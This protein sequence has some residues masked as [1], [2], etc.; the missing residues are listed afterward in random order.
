APE[1]DLR[2]VISSDELEGTEDGFL[3]AETV[4]SD[5]EALTNMYTNR[6]YAYADVGAKYKPSEAD[7]T[8]DVLFVL[9]KHQKVHIRRVFLEGN[10]MTRD[11]VIL[12]QVA[13]AD[14]DEYDGQAIERTIQRLESLDYF[15]GVDVE[16]IP[17]GDPSEMDLKVAVEEKPTGAIGGGVGYSS[18][19]G[20]YLGGSVSERNL[21]GKGYNLSL[22]GKFGDDEAG[23]ELDFYN[24]RVNDE[25]WGFGVNSALTE[26]DQGDYDKNSFDNSVRTVHAL[27]GKTLLTLEYGLDFYRIADIDEDASES[28]KDAEGEHAASTF[29]TD[30]ARS[31]V[32]KASFFKSDGTNNAASMTFGGGFLGGSD[33]FVKWAFLSEMYTPIVGDL[34]FHAKGRMGFLHEN[35]GGNDVPTSQR[36]YLGG[37]STIRGYSANKIASRDD[38]GDRIGGNKYLIGNAELFYPLSK[39]YGILGLLFFDAGNAWKEGE[40]FFEEVDPVGGENLAAA[41]SFGVYKSV[42]TGLRWMSPM[43]PLQIEYGYGLDDLD[44][45]GQHKIEFMMGQQF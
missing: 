42:G 1:A 8:V 40:W 34:V 9:N 31:T 3:N 22:S 12:R 29:T 39:D 17:T 16:P 21:F 13:L 14:G 32:T 6:G 28:V 25:Y 27:S 44:E 41:P 2:N 43:G 24:P 5:V 45:S 36:F 26:K 15:A 10:T 20:V 4:R 38:D 30:I 33:H 19:G 7:K 35:I 23:W 18:S 37:I 11:N